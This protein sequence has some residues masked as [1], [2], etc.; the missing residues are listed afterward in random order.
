MCSGGA[1]VVVQRL[2]ALLTRSTQPQTVSLSKPCLNRAPSA[3]LPVQDAVGLGEEEAKKGAPKKRPAQ[4]PLGGD[5][6]A[7]LGVEVGAAA[8]LL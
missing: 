7:A 2:L 6:L 1:N 5:E 3:C 4:E 8:R